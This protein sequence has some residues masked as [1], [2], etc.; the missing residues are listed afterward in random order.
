MKILAFDIG[1]KT[2]SYCLVDM[3]D[4]RDVASIPCDDIATSIY[5][6]ETLDIHAEA[7]RTKA[8]K[9][10]MQE[11]C[12]MAIH[13][14]DKRAAN[15]WGYDLNNIIIEQQPSG[16]RNAQSSVRMK[17]VSHALHAYFYTQQLH[18]EDQ[19]RVPITFVS[20][21]SKLVGLDYEE[22]E[23]DAAARKAGDRTAGGKK[24]RANK[25]HAVKMTAKLLEKMD[26][27]DTP[28]GRRAHAARVTFAGATPKQDDIS[29]AFMLAYAF[30]RKELEKVRQKQLK[31]M[32]KVR[33]RKLKD[34]E[35]AAKRNKVSSS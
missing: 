26:D 27:T 17:V 34:E 18:G 21:S 11:D 19:T 15:F 30:G 16:G 23:A 5:E 2:L 33:K 6:W 12:E 20:P 9:P 3:N 8:A 28:E 10:T 35:K 22:T 32:E 24:Y 4:A 7:G 31:E 13:A 25:L 1:T 14:I 29:D